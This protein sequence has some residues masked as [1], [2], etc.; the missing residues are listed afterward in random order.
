MFGKVGGS[1]RHRVVRFLAGAVLFSAAGGVVAHWGGRTAAGDVP[2][3]AATDAWPVLT[4]T[5]SGASVSG[6]AGAAT[7]ARSSVTGSTESLLPV[8]WSTITPSSPAAQSVTAV[9]VS[10][11]AG[12]TDPLVFARRLAVLVLSYDGWTDFDG[13][14]SGVLWLAAP[15]PLGDAARLVSDL[16]RY[17]PT[18]PV[19][20]ELRR[21][22]E[23]V[24]F[25]PDQVRVSAWAA[26]RISALKL[27]TGSFGV[28][29][30]GHQT[31]T[32]PGAAP[33]AVSLQVGMTL[34]CPPAT[35]QCE[36]DRIYPGPLEQ[37]LGSS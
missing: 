18:G 29:V 17:T 12:Q 33:V 19:V 32:A 37:E 10:R 7:T 8:V 36:I 15:D 24:V 27:P 22:G 31:I 25:T 21:V 26:A 4:P 35:G 2:P 34:A 6:R 14:V 11:L 1:R 30:T 3:A 16:A 28:D 5:T 9:D 23:R 13:R 20:A